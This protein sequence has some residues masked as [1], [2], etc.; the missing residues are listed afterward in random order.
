MYIVSIL[1]MPLLW[2]RPWNWLLYLIVGLIALGLVILIK[3]K[4]KWVLITVGLVVVGLTVFGTW[5]SN[6]MING[7]NHI[8]IT[9]WWWN[10]E[11]IDLENT[12]LS[13]EAM[14]LPFRLRGVAFGKGIYLYRSLSE[15]VGLLHPK[16]LIDMVLLSNLYLVLIGLKRNRTVV[17]TLI[18]I[19]VML[20]ASGLAVSPDKFN[21]WFLVL[22]SVIILVTNGF[23][24]ANFKIWLGLVLIDLWMVT[25]AV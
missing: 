3:T 6:Q 15:A 16:K 10:K 7:A 2:F 22:P 9:K 14:Y 17:I 18:Q 4:S 12:Q 13:K 20:V 8:D 11:L 21:S 24:K 23:K 25:T 19:A 1:F 5:K